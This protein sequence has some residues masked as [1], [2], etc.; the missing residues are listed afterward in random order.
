[1]A[2]VCETQNVKHARCSVSIISNGKSIVWRFMCNQGSHL[3]P[4]NLEHLLQLNTCTFNGSLMLQVI[5]T[6]EGLVLS[7]CDKFVTDV[8]LSPTCE[9]NPE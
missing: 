2:T 4:L 6:F 1:M 9:L 7:Q 3:G 5:L 8:K